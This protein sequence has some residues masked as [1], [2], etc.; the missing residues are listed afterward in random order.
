MLVLGI[1]ICLKKS[2]SIQPRTSIPNFLRIRGVLNG[3]VSGH[4]V[5]CRRPECG[6][7]FRTTEQLA[8]E[9]DLAPAPVPKS[10]VRWLKPFDLK[11][12]CLNVLTNSKFIHSFANSL[13]AYNELLE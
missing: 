11:G 8:R 9:Y 2:A 1:G 5:A 10:L 7:A 4:E 6:H 3:S 12:H 13:D